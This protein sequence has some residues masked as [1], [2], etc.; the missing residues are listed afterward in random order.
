MEMDSG[1]TMAL[2]HSGTMALWHY[3]TMAQ[4]GGN[5]LGRGEMAS[6]GYGGAR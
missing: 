3:G 4:K 6:E 2:W 5:G 1:G